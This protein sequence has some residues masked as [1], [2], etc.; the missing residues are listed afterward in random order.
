M[1]NLDFTELDK[2]MTDLNNLQLDLH[3]ISACNNKNNQNSV[4]ITDNNNYSNDKN[5]NQYKYSTDLSL[6][7]IQRSTKTSTKQNDNSQRRSYLTKSNLTQKQHNNNNN[8]FIMMN[9]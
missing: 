5:V 3:Q 2:W 9:I 4:N 6:D 8:N 7:G 1:V